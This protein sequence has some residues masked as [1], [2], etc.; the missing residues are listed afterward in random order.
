MIFH[1]EHPENIKKIYYRVKI[2]FLYLQNI[3][4]PKTFSMFKLQIESKAF[5]AEIISRSL[6]G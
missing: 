4:N 5:K 6:L 3:N 2:Y 1:F